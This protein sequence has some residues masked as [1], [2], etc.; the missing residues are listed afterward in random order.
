MEIPSVWPGLDSEFYAIE[1][2]I[3]ARGGPRQGNEP[4]TDWLER[5]TRDPALKALR[6]PLRELV[7]LHYRC[8][9]DPR[10][11]NTEDREALR[12]GARKVLNSLG[13]N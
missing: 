13:E 2:K 9:F 4:L 7:R 12:R 8:R 10:G 1:K 11:L 5:A 3:A 6:K